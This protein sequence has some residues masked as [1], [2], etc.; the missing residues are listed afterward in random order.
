MWG[1]VTP[2]SIRK[3]VLIL[4]LWLQDGAR[5]K[6]DLFGVILAF[7]VSFW[8]FWTILCTF[9]T[10]A[11]LMQVVKPRQSVGMMFW[12]ISVWFQ[13]YGRNVQGS[14]ECFSR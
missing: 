7:S 8:L 9:C 14:K 4:F 10:C 6:R 11:G 3:H 2:H 13:T 5:L 12:S 1:R